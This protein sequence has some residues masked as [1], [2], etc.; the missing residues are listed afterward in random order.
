MSYDQAR[1]QFKAVLETWKGQEYL[2]IQE[3][4]QLLERASTLISKRADEFINKAIETTLKNCKFGI[5]QSVDGNLGR[6][7]STGGRQVR[8]KNPLLYLC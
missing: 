6:L 3:N 8:P 4:R 1:K 7:A 2:Q 5:I